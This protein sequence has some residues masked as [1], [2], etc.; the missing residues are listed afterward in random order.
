[1][2]SSRVQ[3]DG[4]TRS[5]RPPRLLWIII[6]VALIIRLAAAVLLP[7]QS[8]LLTDAIGYR[9]VGKVFRQTFH[10]ASPINMPLYPVLV[11]LV[12]AGW[13][14]TMMDIGLSIITVWLVYELTFSLFAERATALLAAGGAAVFPHFIFFRAGRAD[15]NAVHDAHGG[16]L[17]LLVP[18]TICRR[19]GAGGALDL[20]AP[21]A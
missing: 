9:D 11:G 1:M 13:R 2:D 6:A 19:F 20:D 17:R 16:G 4:V 7:D 14:Q 21:F 3:S 15:G 10:F 12:G 5:L 8:A 18:R